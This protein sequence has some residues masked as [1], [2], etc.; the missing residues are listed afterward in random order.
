MQSFNCS[1]AD[2][3]SNA[4]VMS[5][6]K[7]S[8]S[9]ACHFITS[10]HYY[11]HSALSAAAIITITII[12]HYLLLHST[13]ATVYTAI[14]FMNTPFHSCSSSI[15]SLLMSSKTVSH[16]YQPTFMQCKLLVI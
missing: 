10:S 4:Y 16:L 1:E 5:T 11:H 9:P 2:P 12:L 8:S 15:F 13:V 7:T 3:I 6:H 14:H